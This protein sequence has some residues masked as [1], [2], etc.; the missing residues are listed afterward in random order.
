MDCQCV[1]APNIF[2][3][4]SRLRA[5][6]APCYYAR[7][8]CITVDPPNYACSYHGRFCYCYDDRLCD[9]CR[10]LTHSVEGKFLKIVYDAELIGYEPGSGL[11]EE[12]HFPEGEAIKQTLRMNESTI[13]PTC[14]CTHCTTARRDVK[15]MVDN[16]SRCRIHRELVCLANDQ[17]ICRVTC[18][19]YHA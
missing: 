3:G 6:C 8:G 2:G 19:F 9:S 17:Y 7:C 10:H 13:P 1:Y 14:G 4:I 11:P 12:R 16:E 5:Q 15:F 18:L